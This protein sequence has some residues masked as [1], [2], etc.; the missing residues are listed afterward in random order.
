MLVFDIFYQSLCPKCACF[1]FVLFVPLPMLVPI[2]VCFCHFLHRGFSS[3]FIRLVG[4][5]RFSNGARVCKY[6]CG[7]NNFGQQHFWDSQFNKLFVPADKLVINYRQ[8]LA[9]K[10]LHSMQVFL[11]G[12]LELCYR[13]TFAVTLNTLFCPFEPRVILP[14]I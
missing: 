8:S 13:P 6:Y 11:V 9:Q 7:G 10:F 5:P 2:F 3:P 14:T 1:V 12:S 4:A